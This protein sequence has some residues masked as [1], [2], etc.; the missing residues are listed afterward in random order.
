[1]TP[2]SA[3][4][5]GSQ[6]ARVPHVATAVGHPRE[7]VGAASSRRGRRDRIGPRAG[8]RATPGT[9]GRRAAPGARVTSTRSRAS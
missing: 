1:M 5:P 3:E 6:G 2:R 7:H 4:V 8:R 9:V